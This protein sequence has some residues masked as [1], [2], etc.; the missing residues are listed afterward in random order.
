MSKILPDVIKDIL[1][2]HGAL[3]EPK[4]NNCMEAIIPP[5][6][7]QALRVP[8]FSRL[9]F[10]SEALNDNSIYASYE[11]DFFHSIGDL[12][13]NKGRFAVIA[14]DPV[15]PNPEKLL[16][17]INDKI[18]L[19]N[20]V[21]RLQNKTEIKNVSYLLIYFKYTALSDDKHEGIIPVLINNMN[22]FVTP[23]EN[24]LD[25][26]T[27]RIKK[28]DF[29]NAVS[30]IEFKALKSALTAGNKIAGEKL[31]DFIKSLE[32]RLNRDT[33]RIHEYYHSL[34][35]ETVKAMEKKTEKE[36]KDKFEKKLD[37]IEIEK[38]WKI[39]DIISRYALSIKLEPVCIVRIETKTLVF[40]INIKRRLASREF[41]IIYN[42]L[43]RRLDILPCESCF[44]PS[45]ANYICD[46]KL[47]IV[48]SDCF[49]SCPHCGK[50]YCPVCHKN[51]CPKC[52]ESING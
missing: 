19:S 1:E 9:C 12:I 31:K 38:K 28:A 51:S 11:S 10:S 27:D 18:I 20:A 52:A 16:K 7:S 49:K 33:K 2:S 30:D 26:F 17:I 44:Y 25:E 50:Q 34:K 13:K 47:H 42:P 41:P 3:I 23:F 43:S 4:D 21:F 24:G 5:E 22:F 45:G 37:A 39:Q 32:R 35:H 40:P 6:V 8:E 14:F 48:C 29:K 36:E 15:N 46:D